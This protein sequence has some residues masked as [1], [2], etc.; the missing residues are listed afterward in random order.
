MFAFELSNHLRVD[1]FYR[2]LA[3]LLNRDFRSTLSFGHAGQAASAYMD[4]TSE[5]SGACR[6]DTVLL[7]WCCAGDQF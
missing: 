1:G 2:R 6:R 3:G 7:R 5:A 4:A